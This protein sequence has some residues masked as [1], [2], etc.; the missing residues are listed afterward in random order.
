MK[1]FRLI[2]TLIMAA[3]LAMAVI[4]AGGVLAVSAGPVTS[5]VNLNP[6]PATINT[7]VTVTA[8]VDDTTAANVNIQSAE[9]SVN[10]GAWTAMTASDGTFDSP[11]E[12]VTATFPATSAGTYNVCVRGTDVSS[13]V[14]DPV[15]AP[16]TV[17]YLYAFT[18]FSAPIKMGGANKANA[19]QTIPVKWKL[20][21]TS[22]GA[23]VN[24]PASFVALK[25]YAVDCTTLAGDISTA[26]VEKGPGK[27][28]LKSLGKGKWQ[29][30][31][32]TPKTYRSTCRM[33]FVLFSDGLMSPQVLFRFK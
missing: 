27:T 3:A 10:G 25:S 11:T 32:K 29:F 7:S 13:N 19:P 16:L 24:A 15:C 12:N 8:T 28:G 1:R 6:N 5:A 9:F 22:N 17:Q 18:G 33:M 2:S 14:G 31:W 20:S 4:P 26:V 21:L 23:A 30:N